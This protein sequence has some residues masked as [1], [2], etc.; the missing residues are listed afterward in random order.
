[1]LFHIINYTMNYLCLQQVVPYFGCLG[2][3]IKSHA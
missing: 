2:T 1:M 3:E